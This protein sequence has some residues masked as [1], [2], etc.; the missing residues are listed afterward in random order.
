MSTRE[1]KQKISARAKTISSIVIALIM[2]LF[3]TAYLYLM[4]A[5]FSLAGE[6][7]K[8]IIEAGLDKYIN[9]NL[10]ENDKGT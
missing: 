4:H 6:D 5:P 8:P 7:I 10:T 1:K 2:V 3:T 9:Y